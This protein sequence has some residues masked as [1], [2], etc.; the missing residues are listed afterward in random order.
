MLSDHVNRFIHDEDG[1]YV[2]WGLFW[3]VL[4]VGIGGLA[5][6]ITDA[7]RTQTSLQATADAAALAAVTENLNDEKW[8]PRRSLTPA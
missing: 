5:V 1:G 3:F 2:V 8:T 7:Y 4:F 6:D